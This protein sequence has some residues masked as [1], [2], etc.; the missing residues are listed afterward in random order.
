MQGKKS[1]IEILP[2]WMRIVLNTYNWPWIMNYVMYVMI[3]C[4]VFHFG[5]K[6]HAW[7]DVWDA[8]VDAI[9][10]DLLSTCRNVNN[11]FIFL[12][13]FPFQ[14]EWYACM[15]MTD[16][17]MFL[18]LPFWRESYVWNDAWNA[19]GIVNGWLD[20]CRGLFLVVNEIAF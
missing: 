2:T 16:M 14:R 3:F 17:I 4:T 1:L 19:C 10:G 15:M 12:L 8:Y 6:C 20:F 18:K 9:V 13:S 11:L 7:N 5:W